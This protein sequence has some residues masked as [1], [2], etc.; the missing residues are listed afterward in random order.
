MIPGL[1]L[2]AGASSRMGRPKAL[3][4]CGG[5]GLTFVGSLIAALRGG[6]IVDTV[7]VGRRDDD[8]LRAEVD[9]NGARFV[10]NAHAEDGQLSSLLAGLNVVDRPGV[11]G[12]LVTPVDVPLVSRETVAVLIR[13]F[14]NSR[15]PIVRAVHRARHGHPVIFSCSVFDELRGA[16]PAIGAKAVVHAHAADVLNV[17]VDEPAVLIDVDTPEDY[18]RLFAA[19][20]PPEG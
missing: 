20:Q 11:R 5:S 18:A 8:A 7:V 19:Q 12:V 16:D 2:A 10:E 6:G 13:A 1:I 3:L 17:E 9:R 14:D 4:A 15:A